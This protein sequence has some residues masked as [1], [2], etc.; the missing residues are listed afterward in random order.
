MTEIKG[1]W[2]K[3]RVLTVAGGGLTD[4]VALSCDRVGRCSVG[5]TIQYGISY[6]TAPAPFS[7]YVAGYA[8][9]G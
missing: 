3:P 7:A 6:Q 5:G 9:A 8:P 1:A 4:S 2:S